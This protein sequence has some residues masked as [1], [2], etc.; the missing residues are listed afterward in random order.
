MAQIT[1]GCD[2]EH[3]HHEHVRVFEC[4]VPHTQ[5]RATQKPAD[6]ETSA[7]SS[8]QAPDQSGQGVVPELPLPSL[9]ACASAILSGRQR[10]RPMRRAHSGKTKDSQ[11][12]GR[13][14]ALPEYA[15]HC[16]AGFA[17]GKGTQ[18]EVVVPVFTGGCGMRRLPKPAKRT[19]VA[20]KAHKGHCQAL[21]GRVTYVT[22]CLPVPT[23]AHLRSERGSELD[24]DRQS[25]HTRGTI[26]PTRL[27]GSASLH[28]EI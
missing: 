5:F 13:P 6:P 28:W 15:R 1:L 24:A 22:V 17:K 25:R 12:C 14:P 3:R 20:V 8:W 18:G 11:P 9:V 23:Y 10:L 7:H 27:A 21:L 2:H 26:C 19:W 4:R 16:S